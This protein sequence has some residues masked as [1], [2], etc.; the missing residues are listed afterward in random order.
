MDS[1]NVNQLEELKQKIEL[2]S[3]FHQIE[4]LK[5]LSK[6]LCKLNE[7]KNGIFVNMSFLPNEVIHDLDKYMNYI[8]EQSETFQTLEYQKEEFKNIISEQEQNQL[9]DIISYNTTK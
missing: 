2:L 3:K 6:N 8:E 5:I 7:N 9:E 4:I 1:I